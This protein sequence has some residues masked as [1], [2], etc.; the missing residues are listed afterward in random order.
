MKEFQTYTVFFKSESGKIHFD[1]FTSRTHAEARH[2]FRECYRHG[3]YTIIE[4]LT[5]DELRSKYV[6]IL[7]INNKWYDI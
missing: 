7:N 1:N 5:I 3:N 6:E 4:T 2:D